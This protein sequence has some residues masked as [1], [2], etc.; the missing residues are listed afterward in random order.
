MA[1]SYEATEALCFDRN[2]FFV[3][4]PEQAKRRSIP[5][6]ATSAEGA[7]P[8]K[9]AFALMEPIRPAVDGFVLG[10]LQ[11]RRF[12]KADLFETREGICRLMPSLTHE[13]SETSVQ[14]AKELAPV[15]ER[16]AQMLFASTGVSK[17]RGS[18]DGG[19]PTPLTGRNRSAGRRR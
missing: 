18:S 13:L 15:T 9:T 17:R 16:V 2:G 14:W 10:A 1:T 12:R 11:T 19:L 5:A 7:R 4:I 6:R 3:L 8:A